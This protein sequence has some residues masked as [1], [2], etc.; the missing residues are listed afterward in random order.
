[1][2]HKCM[3]KY[4]NHGGH[5]RAL[6]VLGMKVDVLTT[7]VDWGA[8]VTWLYSL[9]LV[10]G[11]CVSVWYTLTLAFTLLQG[12]FW[13][14]DRKDLK[15]LELDKNSSFNQK[16]W[17]KNTSANLK[18]MQINNSHLKLPNNVLKFFNCLLRWDD[19]SFYN[20]SFVKKGLCHEIFS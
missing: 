11:T 13:K 5:S 15:T 3:I 4:T 19:S 20:L 6:G 12:I 10:K 8:Q 14:D 7:I 1:M 16:E 17:L 2:I 18:S 9:F